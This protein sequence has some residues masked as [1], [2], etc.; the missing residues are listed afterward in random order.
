M[1]RQ[2]VGPSGHA[3]EA[4]QELHLGLCDPSLHIG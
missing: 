2:D 4:D 1:G 3:N